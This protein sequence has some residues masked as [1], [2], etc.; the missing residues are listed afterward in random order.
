[1]IFLTRKKGEALVINDDIVVLVV[2]IRADK[3]RLGIEVPKEVPVH[4][5]EV[6]RALRRAAPQ[7]QAEG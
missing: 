1:M 4:S 7:T 3:V 2:E 6:V 5:G